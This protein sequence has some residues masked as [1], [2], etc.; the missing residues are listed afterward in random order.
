MFM[1]QDTCC[2]F[3]ILRL[4]SKSVKLFASTNACYVIDGGITNS[5][6][7]TAPYKTSVNFF[8]SIIMESKMAFGK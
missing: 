2:F 6:T 1:L 5:E 7:T 4:L 8:E 3:A